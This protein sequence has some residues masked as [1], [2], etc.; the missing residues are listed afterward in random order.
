MSRGNRP[1]ASGRVDTLEYAAA[2]ALALL[3]A[4]TTLCLGGY[5]PETMAR[6][7]PALLVV[8]GAGLVVMV[9][10]TDRPVCRAFWWPAPFLIFSLASAVGWAPAA[11]LGW[12]EWLLWFQGALVFVGVLHLAPGARGI[13]LFGGTLAALALVGTVMAAWQRFHDPTW[14]MMGRTQADQFLGRSSGMFGVPNSLA[15]LLELVI[16]VCLV[17]AWSRATPVAA[18]I[19]TGWLAVVLVAGLILTGSR[20]GWIS[21]AV[22]LMLWPALFA[23]GWKRRLIGV[24]AA[25]GAAAATLAAVF[26]L[27][28]GARERMKPFLAGQWEASRPLI[29]RV[30]VRIWQEHP[31][32]GA[33]AASYNVLFEQFRP[34][35]FRNEPQWTHNDYLNTLSDYGVTG[36]ALWTAVGAAVLFW[37]WKEIR[38][39]RS[40]RPPE[41]TITA[42]W[43]WR[44]GLW[45]GLLAFSLHLLV[46][47][48]TKIPALLFAAAIVG[49]LLIRDCP[50]L[51]VNYS[52]RGRVM[53]AALIA[54]FLVAAGLAGVPGYRA[55]ALRYGARQRLDQAVGGPAM[56]VDQTLPGAEVDFQ[57]SVK[58]DPSNGQAWADL[59]WATAISWHVTHGDPEAIG[60]RA[61]RA[62]DRAVALCPVDAE[63][64]VRK[65][66]ALDME[67]LTSDAAA[68]FQRALELAP[69]RADWHYAY[70]Y[71]LHGANAPRT[72]VDREI[73]TCLTLD[74]GNSAAVAL[75]DRLKDIR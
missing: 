13:R 70:A 25:V 52:G 57:D 72:E 45:L 14:L 27:S 55:E 12:R 51:Q 24:A 32:L 75:H 5:R 33:G 60:R 9:V 11:W 65:G 38:R 34:V 69:N 61:A 58:I 6:V 67:G 68:C 49:A 29:W 71:H 8:A 48:H 63:F 47:F 36:F 62:A 7:F 74:P 10:R 39:V 1:T 43:R 42:R 20:G 16:P 2:M 35:G 40:E 18:R 22:A 73:E 21:L 66:V 28:D 46:D 41:H 59:S 30:G 23:R 19:V 31:W 3:V 54:S 15:G 26:F 53:A 4:A 44:Q 50:A 64:W 56:A 37:G 17:L